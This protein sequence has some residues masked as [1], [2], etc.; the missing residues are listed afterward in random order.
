MTMR[1][2]PWHDFT[3]GMVKMDWAKPEDVVLRVGQP[4]K[5]TKKVAP[6]P[7]KKPRRRGRY[8]VE[9]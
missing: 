1:I 9:V 8:E 4:T 6:T 5:I 2:P 3:R 7:S